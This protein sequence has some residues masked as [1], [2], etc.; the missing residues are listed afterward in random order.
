[1]AD[2]EFLVSSATVGFMKTRNTVQCDLAG[3][4][5]C[6]CFFR[7]KLS[8]LLL[9]KSKC[10]RLWSNRSLMRVGL[11]SHYFFFV[12]AILFSNAFLF[13]MITNYIRKVL[14]INDLHSRQ[15]KSPKIFYTQGEMQISIKS[16]C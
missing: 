7:S 13:L 6:L 10:L 1:M 2:I 11:R 4:N 12:Y 5:S 9:V 8:Y 15:S 16:L 3:D 14:N